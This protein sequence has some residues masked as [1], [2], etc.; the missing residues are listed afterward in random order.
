MSLFCADGCATWK[1]DSAAGF[2]SGHGFSAQRMGS[3]R[4]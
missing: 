1:C 3:Q 2:V 4:L